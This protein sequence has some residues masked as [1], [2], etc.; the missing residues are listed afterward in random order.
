MP[1]EGPD[2]VLGRKDT[3]QTRT[4]FLCSCSL[5]SLSLTHVA[6]GA[7]KHASLEASRVSLGTVTYLD[8]APACAG[9]LHLALVSPCGGFF[10]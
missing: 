6:V 2:T 9:S 1:L 5:V 4:E 3:A 7:C 10:F 8:L